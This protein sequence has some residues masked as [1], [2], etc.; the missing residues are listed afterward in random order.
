MEIL[1]ALAQ[2]AVAEHAVAEV[3]SQLF[4]FFVSVEKK[5]RILAAAIGGKPAVLTNSIVVPDA[6]ER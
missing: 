2:I 5:P 4:V 3:S 1:A 6:K